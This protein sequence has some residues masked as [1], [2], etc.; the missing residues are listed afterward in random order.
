MRMGCEIG[1]CQPVSD[2]APCYKG[3][4]VHWVDLDY[5]PREAEEQETRYD[6]MQKVKRNGYAT[7][8]FETYN[9]SNLDDLAEIINLISETMFGGAMDRAI[10]LYHEMG[11]DRE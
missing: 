2:G 8:D 1:R 11:G 3:N 4:C 5:D 10:K 6:S 7:G 9:N